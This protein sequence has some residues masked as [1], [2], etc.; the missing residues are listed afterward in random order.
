MTKWETGKVHPVHVQCTVCTHICR[1]QNGTKEKARWRMIEQNK[2][3]VLGIAHRK[4]TAMSNVIKYN[5]LEIVFSLLHQFDTKTE[6][7]SK[8][9]K[10][11]QTNAHIISLQVNG[12]R[13]WLQ[14]FVQCT[15]K[16]CVFTKTVV[17]HTERA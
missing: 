16:H 6:F 9:Y 1:Y 12:I 2:T 14:A 4:S 7:S 11:N 13:A 17:I 8:K 10:T 15:C 5:S 3:Q